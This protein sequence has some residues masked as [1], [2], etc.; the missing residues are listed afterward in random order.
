MHLF[1]S[2]CRNCR[3]SGGASPPPEGSAGAGIVLPMP[4]WR[5]FSS[6]PR[7]VSLT[8]CAV[9]DDAPPTRDDADRS[10]YA[11]APPAAVGRMQ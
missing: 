3:A 9:A 4:P 6:C 10:S 11:V 1:H 5:D 7:L 8:L 2:A